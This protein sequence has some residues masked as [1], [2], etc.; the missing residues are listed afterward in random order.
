MVSMCSL[1]EKKWLLICQRF[2]M[3]VSKNWRQQVER[4]SR[5]CGILIVLL[6]AGNIQSQPQE[7]FVVLDLVADDR[8]IT[9][10]MRELNVAGEA[11]QAM[12]KAHDIYL[13]RVKKLDADL[14]RRLEDAGRQR[15]DALTRELDPTNNLD[16][17]SAPAGN[18][19]GDLSRERDALRD[20]PRWDEAKKLQHRLASIRVEG[21]READQILREFFAGVA[22]ANGW[23]QAESDSAAAVIRRCNSVRNNVG[24]SDYFIHFDL[25][26]L[27][28]EQIDEITV[29]DNLAATQRTALNKSLREIRQNVVSQLDAAC[30]E[31]LSRSRSTPPPDAPISFSPATP[32]GARIV[33]QWRDDWNRKYQ[34]YSDGR[35]AVASVLEGHLGAS[36]KHAWCDRFNSIL[37]PQLT[38]SRWPDRMIDWLRSHGGSEEQI[39]YVQGLYDR[40]A[41]QRRVLILEAID[42][43]VRA[44]LQRFV[45]TS[46]E[47]KP[48][49]LAYAHQLLEIHRLSRSSVKEFYAVLTPEQQTV[50]KLEEF[51]NFDPAQMGPAIRRSA[52][53]V[54]NVSDLYSSSPLDE[55]HKR[56]Q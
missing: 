39:V 13:L 4:W 37:C 53:K 43:G 7:N 26:A 23:T 31:Y 45:K 17:V 27:M 36:A 12:L 49:E 46:E 6:L 24:D 19:L 51:G 18:A 14:D 54:M 15:L 42:S 32:E 1:S 16:K 11:A 55:Q 41:H 50:L 40:Y 30:T 33:Q 44:R 35:D 5:S 22:D 52:L 20:D 38:S 9:A 2:G 3:A 47:V 8:A 56:S 29:D 28:D 34:I 10:L 25:I 48:L 21:C